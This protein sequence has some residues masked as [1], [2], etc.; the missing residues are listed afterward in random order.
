MCFLLFKKLYGA[1]LRIPSKSVFQVIEY[2]EQIFKTYV[3]KEG[4]QINHEKNLQSRLLLEVVHHFLIQSRHPVFEDHE[5]GMNESTSMFEDDHRVKLIKCTADKY[6]ALR[7]R[8][9]T[10]GCISNILD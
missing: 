8:L 4:H 10:Y 7:S 6:F 1:S 9:F 3:C 2:A 5:Q